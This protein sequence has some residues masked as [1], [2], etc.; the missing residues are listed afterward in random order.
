MHSH[1]KTWP[2]TEPF[3]G[4]E[5]RWIKI[6]F[7]EFWDFPRLFVFEHKNRTFVFEALF[8]P[9]DDEYSDYFVIKEIENRDGWKE[10]Y[11]KVEIASILPVTQFTFDE[12][13]RKYILRECIEE[14]LREPVSRGDAS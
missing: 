5:E 11:S 2:N 3:D 9:L 6:E 7:V 10:E 8:L 4:S 13:K 1:G 14:I 12:T